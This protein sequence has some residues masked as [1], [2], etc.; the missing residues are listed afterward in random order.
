M[1]PTFKQMN[2]QMPEAKLLSYHKA[3]KRSPTKKHIYMNLPFPNHLQQAVKTP[4]NLSTA[5]CPMLSQSLSSVLTS[6]QTSC[7]NVQASLLFY[8][9]FSSRCM[10]P[11]IL[12]LTTIAKKKSLSREGHP[13]RLTTRLEIHTSRI[14]CGKLPFDSYL[15]WAG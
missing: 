7:K 10:I 8:F 6:K 15:K 5:L 11:G 1:N 13:T 9:M 4:Q 3:R 14:A 2:Y 12:A